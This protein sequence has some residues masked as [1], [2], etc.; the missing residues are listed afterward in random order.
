MQRRLRPEQPRPRRLARLCVRVQ[1]GKEG[2]LSARFTPLRSA[3]SPATGVHSGHRRFTVRAPPPRRAPHATP[4]ACPPR[5]QVYNGGKFLAVADEEGFISIM[6]TAGPL[7]RSTA[8][9]DEPKPRAQWL[10]H[11]NAVF[12]IAW[13]KVGA[14]RRLLP[15]PGRAAQAGRPPH[16]AANPAG[17][18]TESA[19]AQRG[20]LLHPFRPPA[21][22]TAP[23]SASPRPPNYHCASPDL[24]RLS[25]FASALC[26]QGD[27]WMLA[28][29]GDQTI[30]LWDTGLAEPLDTFR[31]HTGSVK[32]ICVQPGCND[33][34][35]SGWLARWVH[36]GSGM[37]I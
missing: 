24:S 5:A 8:D 3:L 25:A 29:S 20:C 36:C 28:A 32:S 16:N 17:G 2:W 4:P 37:C 33:V 22:A 35:A 23:C 18:T 27:S 11:K 6:D 7:P 30:S 9:D 13:A 26:L 15:N 10:A 34:F 14:G 12:D 31:A 19:E 1:Q 21:V